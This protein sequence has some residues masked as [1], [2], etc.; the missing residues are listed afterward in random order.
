MLD[1]LADRSLAVTE[2]V[3][4]GLAVGL[5][6]NLEGRERRH[7]ASIPFQLY[8]CQGMYSRQG[9]TGRAGTGHRVVFGRRGPTLAHRSARRWW[10]DRRLR[11]R[12]RERF[13]TARRDRA[14]ER[15]T[16]LRLDL[17]AARRSANGGCARRRRT[18]RV[19]TL[20]SAR[21]ADRLVAGGAH[22]G[23]HR[24]RRE[25]ALLRC[26]VGRRRP[27]S[28]PRDPTIVR[29]CLWTTRSFTCVTAAEAVT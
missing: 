27:S 13:A 18:S 9:G 4:D 3:E 12:G 11:S 19:C 5:A 23:C 25:L 28:G 2:K 14:G 21:T 17:A 24:R 16:H 7:R 8:S 15:R 20:A 26:P 1:E 6:E 29:G 10:P 22:R